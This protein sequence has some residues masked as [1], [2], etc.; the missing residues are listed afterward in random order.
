MCIYDVA[1]GQVLKLDKKYG[2]TL[3][4]VTVRDGELWQK[5]RHLDFGNAKQL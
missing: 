2:R 5:K 3:D 1:S 4:S